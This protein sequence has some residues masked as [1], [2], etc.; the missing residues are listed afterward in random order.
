M[1][2]YK[3]DQCGEFHGGS[4]EIFIRGYWPKLKGGLMIPDQF[5]EREFCSRECF[6]R[7]FGLQEHSKGCAR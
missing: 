5:K 1:T 2:G 6:L 7:H 3:C 4:A